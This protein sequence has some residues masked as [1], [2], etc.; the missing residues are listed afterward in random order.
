[1]N[2]F[3]ASVILKY[4]L[5]IKPYW[6]WNSYSQSY[7]EYR[8]KTLLIKPY[9]NWNFLNTVRHF[10]YQRYPFNQT[11]LELKLISHLVKRSGILLLIKPYWNWNFNSWM[12][13]S[14]TFFSFN[15]TI[16]ELKCIKFYSGLHT[17]NQTILELK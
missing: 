17:F 11:I 4:I 13:T 7:L 14:F 3:F 10:P 12:L 16:L 6:N 5:L 15:Q 1:M 8:K 2:V 9:W